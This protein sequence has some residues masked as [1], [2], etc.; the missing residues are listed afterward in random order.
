MYSLNAMTQPFCRSI[1]QCM[2]WG[3]TPHRFRLCLEAVS[4]PPDRHTR[5]YPV[6]LL[7]SWTSVYCETSHN[8]IRGSFF[9]YLLNFTKTLYRRNCQFHW[10]KSIPDVQPRRTSDLLSSMNRCA[11]WLPAALL[12][13]PSFVQVPE[14]HGRSWQQQKLHCSE[15]L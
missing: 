7:A 1:T 13:C 14:L 3:G 5:V 4:V 8:Q 15:I 9:F 6:K 2:A 12:I 10:H 11:P